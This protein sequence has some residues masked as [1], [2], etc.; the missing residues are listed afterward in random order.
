MRVL[1]TTTK[2]AA[3]KITKTRFFH[4]SILEPKLCFFYRANFFELIYMEDTLRE[5]PAEIAAIDLF[6]R[7]RP[8]TQV[9]RD[10]K[11][12]RFSDSV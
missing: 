4:F 10:D 8:M 11:K 7:V 1:E 5:T 6:I 12:V 9:E 2:R 3:A